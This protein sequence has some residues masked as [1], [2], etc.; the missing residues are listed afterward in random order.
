MN[1]PTIDRAEKFYNLLDLKIRKYK[2]FIDFKEGD[3][4]EGTFTFTYKVG[5]DEMMVET[6][7]MSNMDADSENMLGSTHYYDVK[8]TMPTRSFY[9]ANHQKKTYTSLNRIFA[10]LLKTW[11]LQ[12]KTK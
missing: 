11:A 6:F 1:K 3:D 5:E 9:I 12:L 2:Q 8:F 10:G 7:C 4:G